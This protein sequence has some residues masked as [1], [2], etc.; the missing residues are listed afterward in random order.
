[1]VRG[2]F[3]GVKRRLD[4]HLPFLLF[5]KKE[6]YKILFF[7]KRFKFNNESNSFIGYNT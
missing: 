3:D 1:M 6:M 2:V 4:N 5:I 7:R